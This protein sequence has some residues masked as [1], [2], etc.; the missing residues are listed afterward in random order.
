MKL[1]PIKIT[2]QKVA[3]LVTNNGQELGTIAKYNIASKWTVYKGIDNN[4][5]LVGSFISKAVALNML[6]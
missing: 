6:R 5:K 3:F 2:G 4:A 1:I